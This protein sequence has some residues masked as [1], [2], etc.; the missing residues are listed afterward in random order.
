MLVKL[1]RANC[2]NQILNSALYLLVL[3][4]KLLR[5]I[6][7]PSL[8]HLYKV[9]KSEGLCI[10]RKVDKD[11]LGEGLKVVLNSVLH[12]VVDVDY[13]LFKL[14]KTL[15]DVMEVAINVHGGPCQGNHTWA[16]FVLKVF[17]VRN[18]QALGVGTDLVDNPVV[19]SQHEMKFGVVHLELVFLQKNDFGAFRDVN[20]YARQAFGFSDESE[21]LAIK[22]DIKL[23]V[24]WMS[25]YQ[26]GLKSS[27]CLLDFM[28]PLLAP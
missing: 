27:L 7:D 3:R 28:S 22:V 20:T 26:S 1:I 2:L 8:L 25:D 17:E 14:C 15:M 11:C 13:K 24:V 12:D 23:V 21:N 6:S 4:F 18:Q 10:L 5:L 16:E 19:F 9:V